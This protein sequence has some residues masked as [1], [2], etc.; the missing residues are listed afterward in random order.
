MSPGSYW[1]QEIVFRLFGI[2][3]L[4]GRILPVLWCALQA[5][6]VFRITSQFATRLAASLA[7]ALYLTL[8]L[9]DHSNITAKHRWDSAALALLSVSLVVDARRE[10]GWV[11]WVLSGVFGCA[12]ALCTPSIGLVLFATLAWLLVEKRFSETGFL[13]AGAAACGIP[14]IIWLIL[15]G[16]FNAFLE[17][18]RWLSNSHSGVNTMPYG[19]VMGGYSKILESGE[20]LAKLIPLG[21]AVCLAL[22]AILPILGISGLAW[23]AIRGR[24]KPGERTIFLY[25]AAVMIAF[26]AAT[27]PRLSATM[28]LYTAALPVAAT[29]IWISRCWSARATS[30]VVMLFAAFM[31]AFVLNFWSEVSKGL[32][33]QTPVGL[34]K[35]APDDTPALTAVLRQI[36]PGESLYVH[37]YMPLLYFITQG[38][39]AARFNFL[40]PG[41]MSE[42]DESAVLADLA[43][44]PP[45][46]MM[47]SLWSR[48]DFL[49]LFPGGVGKSER[50]P[51]IESWVDA[52]YEVV[53]PTVA[54]SGYRLMRRRD[55][56]TPVTASL[57]AH[58]ASQ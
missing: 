39:N 52:H 9:E 42:N 19:S 21:L 8:Q 6:L 43:K 16:E 53:E 57:P 4:A 55:Q 36:K 37:P 3:F 23:E 58:P 44:A 5:S 29:A 30:Y 33:V 41:M 20:G 17:Q 14:A 38:K 48:K 11:R 1:L 15:H 56:A 31:S 40:H 27:A 13:I 22:P 45:Q 7:T 46:W 28:L 26:I 2:T 12:A 51:R 54:L 50:F 35:A 47:Y 18:L 49:S 10:G 34:V 25:L 24:V 32:P